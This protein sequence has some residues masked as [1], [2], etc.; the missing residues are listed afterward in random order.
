MDIQLKGADFTYEVHLYRLPFT[1]PILLGS[2]WHTYRE[3]LLIRRVL[4]GVCEGWGE[5]APLPGFSSESLSDVIRVM[6]GPD[7]G[8]RFP[9][10]ICGMEMA[11]QQW[12]SHTTPVREQS[13]I[14][15]CALLMGHPEAI[16]MQ[17]G[18]Y[19]S[20][21]YDAVKL[22]VGMRPLEVEIRLTKSL[23]K[24]LGDRISIRLDANRAWS[25]SEALEF[26]SGIQDAD[27][28]FVEEPLK[29][30]VRLPEVARYMPVALDETLRELPLGSLTDHD[31]ASAIILKPMLMGGLGV[32][33]AWAREATGLGM[34]AVLSASFE[35][36]IGMANLIHLA[37]RVPCDFPVGFDTYRFLEKDVLSPR[38]QLNRSRLS[39]PILEAF[40]I[41][42]ALL[43]RII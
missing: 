6:V 20:L 9:S 11:E 4:P 34:D 2:E 22:K 3:G 10:V 40:R 39:L 14:S 23:R 29:N 8:A 5:V 7:H 32:T 15:Q 41:D 16:L 35:S 43:R 24:V 12:A 17:A 38:I 28:A 42:Y 19:R 1:K 27:V 26:A 13:S 25:F 18:E 36:G 30:R 31:Y 33:E 21:G 37:A